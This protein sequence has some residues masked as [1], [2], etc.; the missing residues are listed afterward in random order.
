MKNKDAFVAAA[1]FMMRD[2]FKS[3][4]AKMCGLP[5]KSQIP[6]MST[7]WLEYI[8]LEHFIYNHIDQDVN[9]GTYTFTKGEFIK[10]RAD[11]DPQF[12]MPDRSKLL[13]NRV[14]TKGHK[15]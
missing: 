10:L 9:H 4:A 5:Y 6:F 3:I 2:A 1:E 13:L 11:T 7:K 12:F 15:F 14:Y 8:V